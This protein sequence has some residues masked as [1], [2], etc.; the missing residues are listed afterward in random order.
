[1]ADQPNPPRSSPRLKLAPLSETPTREVSIEQIAHEVKRITSPVR[2]GLR[3]GGLIAGVLIG[4]TSACAT[5]LGFGAH[6][7]V[8]T[9]ES[10]MNARL[11]ERIKA[12]KD[13]REKEHQET[14][15]GEREHAQEHK[16]LDRRMN[17]IVMQN[18]L[19]LRAAHIPRSQW[20]VEQ[21]DEDEP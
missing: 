7:K 18:Q 4:V 13:A 11:D 3:I 8:E 12:E 19:L 9:S 5:W 1:V 6:K 15:A 17:Q 16:R 14:L 2:K 21:Q 10:T 20:P